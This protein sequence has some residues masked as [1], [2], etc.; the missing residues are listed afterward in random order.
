MSISLSRGNGLLRRQAMRKFVGRCLFAVG[1]VCVALAGDMTQAQGETIRSGAE[2]KPGTLAAGYFGNGEFLAKI[3]KY[4][5]GID[6]VL[7]IACADGPYQ[8]VDFTVSVQE[9]ISFD[10]DSKRPTAGSW[11]AKF[12]ARRC[13]RRKWYNLLMA[14]QPDGK[15]AETV[16]FPGTTITTRKMQPDV[17]AALDDY[18]RS[19]DPVIANCDNVH[20]FDT[21]MVKD[22][23]NVTVQGKE[24]RDVWLEEWTLRGCDTEF[25]RLILF[26]PDTVVGGTR[27]H[28]AK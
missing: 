9:P 4:A 12:E 18:A 10:S 16:M 7:G 19:L 25:R 14:V 17:A 3:L 23:H 26:V 21:K 15:I 2:I 1:F 27:F 5:K 11:V 13:D 6:L 24:Y 20:V 28:I 8:I 22:R